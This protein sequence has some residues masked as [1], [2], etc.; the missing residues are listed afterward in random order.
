MCYQWSSLQQPQFHADNSQRDIN[1]W[2]IC[3]IQ[4]CL[5]L[6]KQA[7]QRSFKWGDAKVYKHV[8]SRTKVFPSLKATIVLPSD[9]MPLSLEGLEGI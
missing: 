3:W 4:R 1:I 9:F 6:T 8:K 7:S 5:R 2:F